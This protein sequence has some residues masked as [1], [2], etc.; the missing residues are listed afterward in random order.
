MEITS[1]NVCLE[2]R[3]L[4]Y[5]ESIVSLICDV[6]L[7]SRTARRSIDEVFASR[8]CHLRQINKLG[9]FARLAAQKT[10]SR[11]RGAVG[12]LVRLGMQRSIW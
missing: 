5:D 7:R 12:F 4:T 1:T 6:R 8:T 9:R 2:Y 11:F 10:P 3:P